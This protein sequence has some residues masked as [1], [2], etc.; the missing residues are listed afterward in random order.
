MF[1]PYVGT[2][3]HTYAVNASNQKAA[4]KFLFNQKQERPDVSLWVTKYI[5]G[6]Y[7]EKINLTVNRFGQK[8]MVVLLKK[9]GKDGTMSIDITKNVMEKLGTAK[10]KLYDVSRILAECK[11]ST[12]LEMSDVELRQIAEKVSQ[13]VASLAIATA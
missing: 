6:V 7:V 9:D 11:C 8:A 2:I 5:G 4:R 13:Y 1:T 3:T 10:K 12:S